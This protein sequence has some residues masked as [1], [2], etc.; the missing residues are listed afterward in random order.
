MKTDAVQPRAGADLHEHR[1]PDHRAPQHRLVAHV[2][3]WAASNKDLPGFVVLISG[4]NNPDGG[5]SV[6]GQRLPAHGLSGRRVP[7]EGRAGPLLAQPGRRGSEGAARLARPRARSRIRSST[8]A[9]GDPET[10]TRIAA[11]EL[12]YRMQ[13]SV[14][15]L[16]DISRSEPAKIHEMYGTEPGQA[17]VRQQLPAGAP[18]RRARGALRPALSPGLGHARRLGRHRHRRPGAEALPGDRPGHRPRC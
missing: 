5:K 10:T 6:L 9:T 12:A 11:Y 16:T 13:T 4:Q 8:R 14:P 7:I 1:A 17:V 2:T 18:A 3:G 15:E